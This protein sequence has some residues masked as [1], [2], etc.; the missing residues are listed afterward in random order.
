MACRFARGAGP[1]GF[2]RP[3]I[4]V[5][6]ESG[7]GPVDAATMNQLIGTMQNVQADQRLLVSWGGFKSSID[8]EVPA[9]FF[10]VRLWDQTTL[11]EQLPEHYERRVF[12]AFRAESKLRTHL[13]ARQATQHQR[14][15]LVDLHQF[16]TDCAPGQPRKDHL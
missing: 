13:T 15:Q 5:Q 8:K 16:C 12:D 1:L 7:D 3:R 10:G 2:G 4:C 6:V 14:C 9:Q 11:I